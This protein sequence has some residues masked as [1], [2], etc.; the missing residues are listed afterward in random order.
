MTDFIRKDVIP[1]HAWL[2][3]Q[4][5]F[6]V[7]NRVTLKTPVD[8]GRARASW[9]FNE[10]SPDTSTPPPGSYGAPSLKPT[11][12]VFRGGEFAVSFSGQRFPVYFVSN[13]L[14]YIIPL[15]MGSSGQAPSGMVSV[16]LA[17][18]S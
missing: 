3:E 4:L 2:T 18:L 12:G 17:E 13:A 6:E 7:F 14:P 15:E 16:T 8:T 11:G 9:T 1:A 5:A 10:G